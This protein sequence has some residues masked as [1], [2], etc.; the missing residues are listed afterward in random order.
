MA[1]VTEIGQRL[2]SIKTEIVSSKARYGEVYEAIETEALQLEKETSSRLKKWDA[3][4]TSSSSLDA[5]RPESSASIPSEMTLPNTNKQSDKGS[6]E[7]RR[8]DLMQQVLQIQ[9]LV[10]Q[11]GGAFGG[12]DADD[13]AQFSKLS[14]R[15]KVS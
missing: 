10:D 9:S 2:L 12:W 3:A 13:H 11:D 7:T 1:D 15:F 14:V 4:S 8:A 6:Q 5:S